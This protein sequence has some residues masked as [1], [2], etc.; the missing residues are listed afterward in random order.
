MSDSGEQTPKRSP[1]DNLR[2]PWAPGQSGNPKGRPKGA[3]SKLAESF[4][5]ILYKDWEE[6]GAVVLQ[7]LREKNPEA[8]VKVV[9]DLLPK[10]VE[11]E[12]THYHEHRAISETTAWIAGLLGGRADSPPEESMPH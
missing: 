1:S 6:S 8:Y 7:Q 11:G 3:R 9:A 5:D 4:L 10:K 2:D 12:L